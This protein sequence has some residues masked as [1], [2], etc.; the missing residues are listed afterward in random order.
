MAE[1]TKGEIGVLVTK[2]TI[3]ESGTVVPGQEPRFINPK[4]HKDFVRLVFR[5]FGR[6][7]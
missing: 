1:G 3:D 7:E 6:G 5:I 2:P 4:A